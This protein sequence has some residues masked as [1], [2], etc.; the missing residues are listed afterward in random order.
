MSYLRKC[1]EALITEDQKREFNERDYPFG[2]QGVDRYAWSSY[3]YFDT[4]FYDGPLEGTW[5]VI[6]D[7]RAILIPEDE[8]CVN[9]LVERTKQR[10]PKECN[11]TVKQSM[12]K[13][14]LDQEYFANDVYKLHPVPVNPKDVP[15]P[16]SLWAFLQGR[17]PY[18]KSVGLPHML[19]EDQYTFVNAVEVT[20]PP[21]DSK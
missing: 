15:S 2:M 13:I 16:W 3:V 12:F 19:W 20:C 9:E 6:S 11:C 21:A 7:E 10:L 4:G 14:V 17:R 1:L 18:G 5:R 8:N